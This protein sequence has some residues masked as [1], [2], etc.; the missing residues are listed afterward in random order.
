MKKHVITSKTVKMAT[1]LQNNPEFTHFANYMGVQLTEHNLQIYS[2]LYH[3]FV[4]WPSPNQEYSFAEKFISWKRFYDEYKET[5]E[6]IINT[7]L[8]ATPPTDPRTLKTV[9]VPLPH[10]LQQLNTNTFQH[11]ILQNNPQPLQTPTG[12][13]SDCS[14]ESPP[15]PPQPQNLS[16]MDVDTLNEIASQ[17]VEIIEEVLDQTAPTPLTDPT[18]IPASDTIVFSSSQGK[19]ITQMKAIYNEKK[20]PDT[21]TKS[22]KRKRKAPQQNNVDDNPTVIVGPGR[23][24]KD[25]GLLRDAQNEENSSDDEAIYAF[26]EVLLLTGNGTI[27]KKTK[28]LTKQS[29]RDLRCFAIKHFASLEFIAEKKRK[30]F[31]LIKKERQKLKTLN[32]LEL[33]TINDMKE[34]NNM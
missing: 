24:T 32:Y 14:K 18:N 23:P 6:Q 25:D 2:D 10:D 5:Q 30:S 21:K 3:N 15:P 22:R 27:R 26:R 1:P 28:L 16:I 13:C 29:D 7:N 17:H 4:G 19:N 34:I 20:N 12:S 8:F 11:F 33:N 31:A 9:N